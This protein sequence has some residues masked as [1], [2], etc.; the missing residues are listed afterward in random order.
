MTI[1][2]EP[3]DE[4]I[5]PFT[6]VPV[7]ARHDGWTEARQRAFIRALT[8]IGAVAAAA[9]S[10]GKS[11]RSVYRLRD[12]ADAESFAEAWDIAQEMGVANARDT[13]IERALN[14]EVVPRFY[15]GRRVG[16]VHRYNDRLL[17]AVLAGRN[18]DIEEKRWDKQRVRAY[19]ASI[20]L[21]DLRRR[22]REALAAAERRLAE[23]EAKRAEASR[24]L[25]AAED[26]LRA[27]APVVRGPPRIT[28]L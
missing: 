3:R 8:R 4:D 17:L 13:A 1:D 12:R 21:E 22:E 6:P 2:T 5:I 11:A 19:R 24:A 9:K 15:A 10:V 28:F 16:S 7:R 26:A 27:P 25:Q 18:Q 23:A 20:K 14:G